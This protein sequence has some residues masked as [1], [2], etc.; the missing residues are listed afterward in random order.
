MKKSRVMGELG[1][2]FGAIERCLAIMTSDPM[3][4]LNEEETNELFRKLMHAY[5][6]VRWVAEELDKEPDLKEVQAA[7]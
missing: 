5:A 4:Q 7:K 2:A 1:T 3:H 6:A